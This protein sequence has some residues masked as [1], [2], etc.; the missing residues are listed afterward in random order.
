MITLKETY[1]LLQFSLTI[2]AMDYDNIFSLQTNC[3]NFGAQR[4][5]ATG[6]KTQ[7]VTS[8]TIPPKASSK[9]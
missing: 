5:G 4:I 6:L 3:S 8:A 2:G 9:V 1:S 7:A